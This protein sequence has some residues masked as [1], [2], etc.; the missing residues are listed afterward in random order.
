M[1][2][3]SEQEQKRPL[4]LTRPGGRLELPKR[5]ETAQVR[6]SS[7]NGRWKT[8]TVEVSRKR[9]VAP[10]LGERTPAGGG[11]T[12]E[13][14]QTPAAPAAAPAARRA[15]VVMRTLTAEERAGRARAV[16]DAKKADEEA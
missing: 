4:S 8:V 10:P 13:A 2:D 7:T 6:Q 14:A 16:Q 11:P 5:I 3:N 1:T 12:R 15:P 9:G